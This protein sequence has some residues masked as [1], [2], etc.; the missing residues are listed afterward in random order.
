SAQRIAKLEGEATA[1]V[2]GM[3]ATFEFTD[4]AQARNVQ[5]QQAGVTVVLE[6][7][8]KNGDLHEFRIRVVLHDANPSLQSYLDWAANNEI[9][10]VTEDGRPAEQPSY[11]KYLE[12]EGE[13][14]FAYLFP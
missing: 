6:S 4:L 1:L 7:V 5:Q 3:M 2:P 11:E 9:E 13:V 12:R 8:R 10:L 14:G